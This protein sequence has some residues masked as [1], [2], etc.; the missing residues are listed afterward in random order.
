MMLHTKDQGPCGC[1]QE[2]FLKSLSQES[3]SAHLTVYKCNSLELPEKLSKINL[4][5]L[6]K[7]QPG[8][9]EMSFEAIVDDAWVMTNHNG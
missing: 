8:V 2:D 5:C 6:V 7:I 4:Q 1:R 3:I 9:L